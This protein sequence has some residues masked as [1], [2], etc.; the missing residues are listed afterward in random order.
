[1][2]KIETTL[3]EVGIPANQHGFM[4]LRDGIRLALDTPELRYESMKLYESIAQANSTKSLRVERCMRHS[5]ETA[6]S[7]STPETLEMYFGSSVNPAKGRPTISEFI[8][9]MALYLEEGA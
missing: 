1:M 2:N 5:I 8:A 3:L 4:Y 9:T 6:F 7:R